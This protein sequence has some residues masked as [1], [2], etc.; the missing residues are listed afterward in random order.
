[1]LWGCILLKTECN[2]QHILHLV[3]VMEFEPL[4]VIGIDLLDLLLILF[5][6]HDLLEAGA[7]RGEDFLFDATHRQHFTAQRD[8]ASHGQMRFD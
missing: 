4:E 8:F 1:M 3:N 6:Q 7:A 2:L 5:T